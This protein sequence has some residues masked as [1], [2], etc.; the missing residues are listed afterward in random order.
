MSLLLA[1]LAVAAYRKEHGVAPDTLDQLVSDYLANM[2]PDPWSGKPV[3]LRKTA[4]GVVVYSVGSD[5]K[6]DGGRFGGYTD[7]FTTPGFDYDL[8]VADR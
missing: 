1:E 8:G 4:D 6:D 7:V 3:I 5:G 2:P